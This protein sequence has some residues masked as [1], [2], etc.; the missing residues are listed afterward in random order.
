MFIASLAASKAADRAA[1]TDPVSTGT[2]IDFK[3]DVALA[4]LMRDHLQQAATA[5]ESAPA[6][7]D[8]FWPVC[9]IANV[10]HCASLA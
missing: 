8:D 4:S 1:E 2:V 10:A 9:E 3:P 6:P 7:V 5:V